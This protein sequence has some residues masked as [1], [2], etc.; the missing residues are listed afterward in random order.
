MG[1]RRHP[2][3]PVLTRHDVPE[4]G[5]LFTDVSAVFNPGVARLGTG[6]GLVVRVQGR[7]RHTALW[8]ATSRDGVTITLA[9]RPWD[10][11]ALAD[12]VSG[13]IHH[14]YDARVTRIEGET[15]EPAEYVVTVAIDTSDGCRLGILRSSRLETFDVV[16]VTPDADTRNAVVFPERIGGLWWR[17]HRPNDVAVGATTS[18]TTVMATSSEDLITWSRDIPVFSGRPRSWD[19][20]VGPGPPPVR[21]VAGWLVVYHGVATHAAGGDLYQAGA[22]LLDLE[23]PTRV[24]GRSALNVLEP[25]E[26]YEQTGQVPNVVFPSGIVL[27]EL[28][29]PAPTVAGPDTAVHVY[30]GAADT[31]VGLASTTVGELLECCRPETDGPTGTRTHDV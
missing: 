10:L 9:S 7:G 1:L 21:T 20:R 8:P 19:E 13:P 2:T 12:H 6:V 22:V 16:T 31:V 14:V 3:N 23:D 4:H 17:L 15:G 5:P 28:G 27:G 18:G 11:G 25:R 29:E 30:Y 26:P 24:L